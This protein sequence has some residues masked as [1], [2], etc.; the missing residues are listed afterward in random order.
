MTQ[1]YAHVLPPLRQDAADRLDEA[2]RATE[3]QPG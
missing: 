2:L 1:R 3:V